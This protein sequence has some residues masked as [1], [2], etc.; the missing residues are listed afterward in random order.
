MY[1]SDFNDLP[2][3][4][5]TTHNFFYGKPRVDHASFES[6]YGLSLNKARKE[7]I[8]LQFDGG[9]SKLLFLFLYVQ[10]CCCLKVV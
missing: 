6:V 2:H 1:S 5:F 4:R 3:K 10:L 8:R 9:D 7:S